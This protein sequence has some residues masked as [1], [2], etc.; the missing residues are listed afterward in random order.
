MISEGEDTFKKLVQKF[1]PQN[2][3]MLTNYERLDNYYK[4]P[5]KNLLE[6]EWDH[7][8]NHINILWWTAK[9]MVKWAKLEA[10][11]VARKV[12]EKQVAHVK[13]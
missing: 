11:E 2:P 1:D 7:Y 10:K 5:S 13:L 3:P 6:T 8:I 12:L 4:M 9:Y